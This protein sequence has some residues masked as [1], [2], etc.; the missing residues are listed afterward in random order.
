MEILALLA[1]LAFARRTDDGQ[2]GDLP[3]WSLTP[4]GWVPSTAP[5]I[6]H[7]MS[8]EE[9]L[10]D[11]VENYGQRAE[12]FFEGIATGAAAGWQAGGVFGLPGQIV[13]AGIGG[14]AGNVLGTTGMITHWVQDMMDYQDDDTEQYT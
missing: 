11:S 12:I 1:L 4:Y 13:G 5:G 9:A 10:E 2:R 8:V 14:G 3:W 7:Q 6:G